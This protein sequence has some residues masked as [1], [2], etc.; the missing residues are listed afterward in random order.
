MTFK[1]TTIAA[2]LLQDMFFS[3]M[4]ARRSTGKRM[5]SRNPAEQKAAWEAAEDKR[6]RKRAKRLAD[7]GIPQG[8]LL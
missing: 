5:T 6:N 3:G 2:A 8:E 1:P 4:R 7:A